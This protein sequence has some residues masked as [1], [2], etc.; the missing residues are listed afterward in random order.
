MGTVLIS[1][2]KCNY[3]IYFDI[4]VCYLDIQS[5]T[6]LLGLL[7][8]L[9]VLVHSIHSFFNVTAALLKSDVFGTQKPKA[10]QVIDL[11]GWD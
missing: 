10:P 8:V 2:W 5:I 3:S 6:T 1:S 4:Q 9:Y 11:Q 7:L